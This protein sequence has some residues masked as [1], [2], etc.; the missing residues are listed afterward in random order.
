MDNHLTFKE[1]YIQ[2]L[3]VVKLTPFSDVRGE[4]IRFFCENEG[5]QVQ[6]RESGQR[7]DIFKLYEVR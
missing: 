7:V 3:F 2:N 6:R 4:F 5:S 1:T